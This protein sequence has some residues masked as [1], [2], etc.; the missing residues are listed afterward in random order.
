MPVFRKRAL[1]AGLGIDRGWQGG[2]A[3]EI[4]DYL[5]VVHV[6]ILRPHPSGQALHQTGGSTPGQLFVSWATRRRT[7]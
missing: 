7:L 3:A 1:G 2:D 5:E 4:V 6:F